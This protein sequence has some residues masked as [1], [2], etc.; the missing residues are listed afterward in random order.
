MRKWNARLNNISETV[1]ILA[2][3]QRTWSYL[4][5]L[6]IGSE[7][8]RQELPEDAKRFADL[9]VSMK[10]ILREA[11]NTGNTCEA[12]NRDG[13][14]A[15]LNKLAEDLDLCKKSLKDFLDG[16]RTIF[17]RFYF[18]SEAQ[19]LDLLSNGSDPHKIMKYI[20]SVFSRDK[21]LQLDPSLSAEDS[22]PT[23]S[24]EVDI[25][26]RSRGDKVL[27]AGQARGQARSV[28]ANYS[29]CAKEHACR[30]LRK[31]SAA[32]SYSAQGVLAAKSWKAKVG[33]PLTQLR[34]RSSSVQS[35]TCAKSMKSLIRLKKVE[36]GCARSVQQEAD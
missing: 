8:V 21:T 12:C 35:T 9:D 19:L 16:K 27:I 22:A 2:E 13:L 7:E 30:A 17:P 36:R 26:R 23:K 10:R 15:E 14:V 24:A 4:E 31:V 33:S 11:G 29:G 32:L 1:T 6:F 5:P 18:V 3:I 34:S 28:P 25:V 20:T